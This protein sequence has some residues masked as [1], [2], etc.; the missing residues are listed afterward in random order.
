MN[1]PMEELDR[2]RAW[3]GHTVSYRSR[4][5]RLA[6]ILDEPARLI[7]API[8]PNRGIV[9]DSYGHPVGRGPE[10]LELPVFDESG[11]VSEELRTVALP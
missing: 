6:E 1:E 2:L 11:E 7:L 10:F 3:L 5:Y 4:H 8:G 9:A